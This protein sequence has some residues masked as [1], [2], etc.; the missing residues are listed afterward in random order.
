MMTSIIKKINQIKYPMKKNSNIPVYNLIEEHNL[1]SEI[2]VGTCLDDLIFCLEQGYFLIW[3]AVV[4]YEQGLPLSKPQKNALNDL[5]SFSDD[6]TA[7]L[8]IDEMPRPAE[9]W[10]ETVR[11]IAPH[12]LLESFK[13]F[14][15]KDEIYHDGWP[16]LVDCLEE[17]ACDLSLPEGISSPDEVV[18]PDIRHKLWLQYCFDELSG[19]GQDDELTLANEDQKSWRIEGFIDLLKE[20]KDSVEFL[21]LTLNDLLKMVI[22]LP[23]DEKILV[24]SLMDELGMKSPSDKLAHVL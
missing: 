22:L 9:P 3:E 20:C 7:I 10:Y 14:D 19:L 2:G 11:K 21:D 16:S 4:R 17:H 6:E 5:V 1:N 8:Y 12:L 18:Q 13:T 23:E 15:V 24:E